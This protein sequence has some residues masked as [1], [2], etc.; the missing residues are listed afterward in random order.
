MPH[1]GD[2]FINV[3]R[4]FKKMMT[5][6]EI[7]PAVLTACGQP[8]QLEEILKANEELET[9]LKVCA[10][11]HASSLHILPLTHAACVWSVCGVLIT[12]DI[13]LCLFLCL[14]VCVYMSIFSVCLTL[15]LSLSF[16]LCVGTERLSGEEASLL[17]SLLFPLQR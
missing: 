3:D 7:D 16:S 13:V 15:S 4:Q 5:A 11:R 9:I 10:L 12:H 14:Y 2:L 17:R 8:G 1:E 6:C